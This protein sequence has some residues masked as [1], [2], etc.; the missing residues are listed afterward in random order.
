MADEKNWNPYME[1]AEQQLRL[2]P[3]MPVAELEELV[4]RKYANQLDKTNI[5]GKKRTRWENMVDWV[6]AT[7]TR[8]GAIRYVELGDVR[9]VLYLR[10]IATL[11][12]NDNKEMNGRMLVDRTETLRLIEL[13]IRQIR[14]GKPPNANDVGVS[15]FVQRI[16]SLRAPT[17]QE[18]R[19]RRRAK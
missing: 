6:K 9:Y 2:E 13:L 16:Q 7:L 4:A 18:N 19:S 15:A 14:L 11:T 12:V 1:F 5:S 3:L 17:E 10:P 8:R